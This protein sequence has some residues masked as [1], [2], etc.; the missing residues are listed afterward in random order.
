M[1]GN[2]EMTRH[3]ARKEALLRASDAN[4]AALHMEMSKL[5]E[6]AAWADAGVTLSRKA[7]TIWNVVAPLITAWRTPKQESSGGLDWLAKQQ[8]KAAV[9]Q[10]DSRSSD[11][12]AQFPARTSRTATSKTCS[13]APRMSPVWPPINLTDFASNNVDTFYFKKRLDD[14]ISA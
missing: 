5:R 8:H 14:S 9:R 2:G 1:F 4:R 7:K 11:A 6:V 10:H 12:H 13:D 3:L